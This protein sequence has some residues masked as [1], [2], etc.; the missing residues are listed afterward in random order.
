[1][2]LKGNKRRSDDTRKYFMRFILKNKSKLEALDTWSLEKIKAKYQILLVMIKGIVIHQ[3]KDNLV[4]N[5]SVYE[6]Y[7]YQ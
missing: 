7:I 6:D 3:I 5:E 2:L 4:K 1:M